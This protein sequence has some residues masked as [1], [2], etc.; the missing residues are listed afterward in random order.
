[1]ESLDIVELIENNPITKLSTDYNIKLLAKIKLSFTKFEQQL[2][3]SSFYCYLNYHSSNDFIIDLDNVW[4]WLGFKQKYNA[5]RII[6]KHFK[7]NIDYKNLAPPI[8]G[9]S[10]D[11]EKWGGHNIKKIYLTINCFKL[12]CLKAGTKKADEIHDYFIKLEEII[13]DTIQEES[14]ELKQQ[15]QQASNAI[16][17]NKIEFDAKLQREKVIEREKLLLREFATI[18]SIIYIIKVKTFENGQYV[19]KLGESAKGVQLRY[20]EHKTNYEEVL[21]LDCFSVKK[22]K[23]FENFLHNHIRL[24]KVT[25]LP[26]H[27]NERE[28]FLIGKELSYASLLNTIHSNIKHFNEYTQSD[29]EKLTLE[30]EL[31]KQ[32]NSQTHNSIDNTNPM[33]IEL[34]NNQ[35]M[36]LQHII[37]LE[38]SNQN[39]EKSNKEILEKLNNMQSKT[40][41]NFQ[42]PLVTLGPRL[43]KIHPETL[44][45]LKVYD[46]IA[47]CL[48]EYNFKIKRPS[49]TKAINDNTVYF[50]FRWRFVERTGDPNIIENIEPTKITKIQNLGY[51]AKLNKEKTE[52]INV[53]LDRKIACSCNGYQSSSALD[54]PVKN[55]T[56]SNGC[57]YTLY[58][59]CDDE[60]KEKFTE[61]HGEPIL[62]KNGVGQYDSN[63]TLIQEFQ[64]KYDCIKQLKIGDKTLAKTLDKNIMYN[65]YYFKSL[66]NKLQQLL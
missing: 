9:A 16:Q 25:D 10:I 32:I 36:L 45:L 17:T 40:T 19:I 24:H 58:D 64:C 18:G 11:N 55:F 52:I 61:Q 65:N 53:Y 30:N 7:L 29:F 49:I 26:G 15:L 8:G 47:E 51:I 31:L 50:G 62:Y 23:E 57:Y 21:L 28:L 5:L 43:Q 34:V 39:L 46:S 2:F 66:G 63:H 60:L 20:N 6:E 42:Q 13:Q 59:K 27:E 35:K 22:H 12:L 54:N 48:K 33:I 1:M 56:L 4:K 38:K 44:T 14:S 37:N 41:T 3:L